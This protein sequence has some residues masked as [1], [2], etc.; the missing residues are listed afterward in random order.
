MSACCGVKRNDFLNL[1]LA[2]FEVKNESL[3]GANFQLR[4]CIDE[5]LYPEQFENGFA[6]GYGGPPGD[7]F[8]RENITVSGDNLTIRE[9]L[10]EIAIESH[11]ALWI[12]ELNPDELEGDKPKWVGVPIN[13]HGTSPLTGRWHFVPIVPDEVI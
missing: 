3:F 4:I 10:N 12:V 1:R 2:G 6:G 9:I 8:W 13:E 5:T 7:L 11:S